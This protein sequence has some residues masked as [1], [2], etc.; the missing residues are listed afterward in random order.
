M[1]L[2]EAIPKTLLTEK[3]LTTTLHD[4]PFHWRA[5]CFGSLPSKGFLGRTVRLSVSW[6]N[7][8]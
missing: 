6:R 3:P 4:I 1:Q 8:Q 2:F 5:N 7:V